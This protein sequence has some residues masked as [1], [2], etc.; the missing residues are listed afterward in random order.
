MMRSSFLKRLHKKMMVRVKRF[1]DRVYSL[2][3]RFGRGRH[4]QAILQVAQHHFGAERVNRFGRFLHA[5]LTPAHLR[6]DPAGALRSMSVVQGLHECPTCGLFQTLLEVAP[7]QVAYCR[8][9][10]EALVRRRRTSPL[11]TPIAFCMTSFA[12]YIALLC[13]NLMTLDAKGRVNTISILTGVYQLAKQ[14]YGEIGAIVAM[15]TFIMPGIVIVLMGIVLYGASRAAG[16]DWTAHILKWY[17]RLREW[18]MIE[19]YILGVF[20]AYTKLVDLALVDLQPGVFLVAAI[21][22]TMATTDST[23]DT[24]RVWD[25]QKMGMNDQAF[26]TESGFLRCVDVTTD[27]IPPHDQMASCLTCGLVIA[28]SEPVAPT[29]AFGRCPRCAAFISRRKANALSNAT[30]LLVAGV[31]AYI[32]ANLFPVMTFMKV[33]QRDTSTIIHGAI[34]LW[35]SNLVPLSLLVIFAS[36]CVPVLKIVGLGTMVFSAATGRRRHLKGLTKLYRVIDFIGRWSMIDVFM[37]SILVA[38][39]RFGFLANVRAEPGVVFFTFVVIA[40]IFAVHSFDIRCLWDGAGRNGAELA[41]NVRVRR[42]YPFFSFRRNRALMKGARR[43][44]AAA[45]A[46]DLE[47]E[48]A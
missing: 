18:A 40:T 24:E 19:V 3:S 12:L 41:R 36:I 27:P 46:G 30:S 29:H 7:G 47:S 43:V 17:R 37:I 8:R 39:V 45:Q 35:Q 20:V 34:E 44:K 13:S 15:T 28:S 14:G 31:L 5:C 1:D 6:H 48:K 2:L 42:A 21:M 9:C 33:G 38:V 22:I 10:D 32:P 16:T 11:A 23:L 4:G 26:R 25:A